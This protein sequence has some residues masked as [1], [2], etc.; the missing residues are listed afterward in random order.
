MGLLKKKLGSNLNLNRVLK[1]NY[2]KFKLP[3]LCLNVAE[4]FQSHW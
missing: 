2:L 4:Q 3:L 1:N